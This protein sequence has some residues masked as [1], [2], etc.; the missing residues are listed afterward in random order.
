MIDK[1]L[2]SSDKMDWRTPSA[3]YEKLNEEFNFTLVVAAGM[4]LMTIGINSI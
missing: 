1:V 2:F 4:M 3:L